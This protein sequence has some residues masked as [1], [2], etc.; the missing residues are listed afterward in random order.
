MTSLYLSIKFDNYGKQ[1][2][3][4]AFAIGIFSHCDVIIS[5]HTITICCTK[6]SAPPKSQIRRTT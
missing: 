1:S 3:T 6:Q 5:P 2:Y 4:C